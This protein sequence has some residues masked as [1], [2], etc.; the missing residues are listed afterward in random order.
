MGSAAI[1]GIIVGQFV[2]IV[3]LALEL[4][5]KAVPPVAIPLPVAAS[6]EASLE[7]EILRLRKIPLA[8][9]AKQVDNSVIKAKSA[10]QVRQITESVWGKPG[11]EREEAN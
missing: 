2:V 6:R 9:D 7:A 3:I 8:Q 1:A 10:A 4:Y 5:R 11:D